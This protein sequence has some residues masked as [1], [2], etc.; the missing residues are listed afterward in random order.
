MRCSTAVPESREPD[1]PINPSMDGH[2]RTQE[3]S[4]DF[5]GVTNA[6][7]AHDADLIRTRCKEVVSKQLYSFFDYHRVKVFES[8]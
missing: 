5:R 2:P 6:M 4:E 8:Y 1:L 7:S 3:L